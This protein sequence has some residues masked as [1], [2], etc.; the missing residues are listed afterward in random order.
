ML[1]RII[2]QIQHFFNISRKEARGTLVLMVLIVILIWT[3]FVFRR[4]ILPLFPVP[5]E[6]ANI[7]KLDSIVAEL[8]N[9]AE[10]KGTENSYPR[11][12]YSKAPKQPVRLFT[13]NPN[14]ASIEQLTELGI[15]PFLAK[16]MDKYR[17]KGGQFRKKEDLLHIYDFPSDLYKTLEP[18]ISLPA[19]TKTYTKTELKP[20]YPEKPATN[21]YVREKKVYTK[22]AIASFDI[23]TTDTTQL[24]KLKGIGSKL[25]VR[26]LKFRDA[27]G[28]FYST[29]QFSE[30][31]GLDSLALSEL[32]RYAKVETPVKK[33]NINTA[34]AEELSSHSYLRNKKL[35]SVIVNYR[36]QHGSFKSA[37]DLKKVKVLDENTIEKLRPYLDF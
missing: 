8:N 24:V 23:N 11:K 32:N 5:S 15:P 13:F 17:N 31:F 27:L 28:G 21:I 1:K 25:S 33:I 12:E 4:W 7:Q 3:P 29:A 35:A 19:T 10:S 18:Y 16:R 14:E 37:E 30:I 2:D 36:I 20:S 6:P 22:P 26:I 34:T 9:S